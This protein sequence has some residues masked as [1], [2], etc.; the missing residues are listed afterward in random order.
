MLWRRKKER[1]LERELRSDLEL[2]AAEREDGGLSAEEARF[3]AQRALG[4]TISVKEEVREMWGWIS[5]ER[6]LQDLRYAVRTLRKSPAFTAVA[7]L[8][9][10][11][12]IGANT[13]LFSVMDAMLLRMLPVTD[14]QQLVRLRTSI[15]FPAFQKVKARN[16]VFSG[17]FAYTYFLLLPASI[18]IDK[19]PERASGVFVSGDYFSVLGVTAAAGR[20][21][22]P[23]DDRIPGSGGSQGPVAVISY[24]YWERRFN[25]NPSVLG[26]SITVNGMPVTVVGVSPP[27]FSGVDPTIMPDITMPI[28]LQPRMSPSASTELWVHGD[29]GSM[30]S[31]DLTDQYGP[32]LIARLKPGVTLQQAQAELNVIYQQIL[33]D[34]AGGKLD[35]QKRRENLEKRLELIPAGN[36]Y[37][38]MDAQTRSLLLIILSAVPGLVLLIACANVANLLLARAAA[39]EREVAVRLSIG[40]G[41][42]RLI[43]Q[44]LTE[45]VVLGLGGAALGLVFASF[46]R[47]LILNWLTTNI[48]FPFRVA[49]RTDARVLGFTIA[50][51]VGA[52]LL[53]GLAPAW[54]AAHAELGPVL[55]EG[56]RGVSG[57]RGWQTGKALVAA[58]VALSL[59]LLISAG[60][61]VRTLRNLRLFDPGFRRENLYA[62]WTTFQGGRPA[63]GAMVK[64]ISRLI[65]NLPG[66]I[67]AAFTFNFPLDQFSGARFKISVDGPMPV[68]GDDAYVRRLL[69]GPDVLGTVGLQLLSGRPITERDDENAPKVCL[70]SA[71]V[72]R[73]LFPG[74]DP[75][76]RRFKFER[77]GAETTPEIIGVVSDVK[78]PD[79]KDRILHAVYC[80]LMQDLPLGDA[81][82]LVRTTGD[83]STAINELR[84]RFQN[85]DRNLFLDIKSLEARLNEALILQ[86]F[87]AAIASVFGVL[88]L[89]LASAGLYGV[90]A[91]SV[92]RRT[93]EIGIRMALG[94]GRAKVVGMVLRETMKLVGIGLVVGLA[95]ALAATRLV[96]TSLFGVAPTDPI[97]IGLAVVVMAAV[98]IL[99]G[100][101]PARRAAGVDPMIALRHE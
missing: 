15:S 22:A 28:M 6:L 2:E 52:A 94:A 60:L 7:L 74:Q 1:D 37:E 100:Y 68:S 87:A 51:A 47:G 90:M 40:A 14:P 81:T 4:N 86:R 54:R 35:D 98:A 26:T 44:F 67:S 89:V 34:R 50:I 99:A 42:A 31:Y 33:A 95:A 64:E 48:N 59:L 79:S 78:S 69:I 70:I 29:Q 72:A 25:L 91:Y 101:A 27:E 5:L 57:G 58:Q 75:V 21:I 46:G 39:R 77:T 84:R 66:A 17:E 32:S 38:S 55:K 43:R 80:P 11:L 16:R 18:R 45:S 53:F 85:Y 8:S 88:A 13:A 96:A 71:T 92:S 93:N 3:A 20:L 61:L 76:G 9:L 83:P 62:V 23:E 10:A 49:A 24:P 73:L 30:I 65:E 36:G 19:E 41:R 82:V 63:N 56:S 12:G 97:T